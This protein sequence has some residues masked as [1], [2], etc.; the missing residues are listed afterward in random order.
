MSFNAIV[1]TH[2]LDP[3][4]CRVGANIGGLHIPAQAGMEMATEISSNARM[5]YL[6]TGFRVCTRI[7]WYPYLMRLTPIPLGSHDGN[8]APCSDYL[9]GCTLARYERAG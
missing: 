8:D 1:T 9:K 3:S 4:G 7:G 2:V 5:V 6:A